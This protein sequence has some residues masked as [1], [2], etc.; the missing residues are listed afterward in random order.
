MVFSVRM[1]TSALDRLAE[2]STIKQEYAESDQALIRNVQL[3]LAMRL[4]PPPPFPLVFVPPDLLQPGLQS[5]PPGESAPVPAQAPAEVEKTSVVVEGV[6][7]KLKQSEGNGSRSLRT[8]KPFSEDERAHLSQVRN[9]F[10]DLCCSCR[11][12]LRNRHHKL[13]GLSMLGCA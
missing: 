10:C 12:L 13:K 5:L 7:A 11:H 3:Q 6:L 8:R 4:W 1:S 2:V 9:C